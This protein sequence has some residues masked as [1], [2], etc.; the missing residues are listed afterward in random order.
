MWDSNGG[1]NYFFD[2]GTFTY[3]PGGSIL[4]GIP[5]VPTPDRIQPSAPQSLITTGKTDKTVNLEWKASTD[6]VGV[7]GY[8]ILRNGTKVATVR[9]AIKWQDSN[10]QPATNYSYTVRAFDAAGNMSALSNTVTT[11]TNSPAPA[12]T[13]TI[14]YKRGLSTPH[15]HYRAVGGKWTIAPGTLMQN[16]EIS[17]YS[18]IT[19]NIGTATRLE[20]CF[21]N[22]KGVWDSNGG[23]NYLFDAGVNTFI[24]AADGRSAG[25]ITKAMPK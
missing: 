4:P 5:V 22:G 3:I 17:G 11:M 8:D 19:I 7:I 9:G 20:A 16:A 21:N 23:R 18:K 15:I 14:Y 6:N 13:V 10:L 1:K 25:T 12:N 2:A 24:P